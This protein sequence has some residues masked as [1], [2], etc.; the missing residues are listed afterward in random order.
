MTAASQL[1][2]QIATAFQQNAPQILQSLV[3][4]LG[5]LASTIVQNAP[6]ILAAALNLA[7]AIASGILKGIGAVLH[8]IG[9]LL[10]SLGSKILAYAPSL[11]SDGGRLIASLANGIRN[12]ASSVWAAA[13]G[14]AEKLL[15]P[16]ET[17]KDKIK[18]IIEKIKDFFAFKVSMPKIPVPHFG[19]SPS[20]WRVKD[21]LS[22]T[23]PHLSVKWYAKG[24]VF[25]GPSV[26]G[27]GEAGPEAVVP[28]TALWQN[29][30]AMADS[31]VNGVGTMLAASS[32][33]GAGTIHITLNLWPNGP[34]AGEWIV[35]T[36]DE[37]KRK[38]G[39]WN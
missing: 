32:G 21:L 7:V 26:I 30:T 2:S 4:V 38:K 33:G 36:Y 11:L 25:D 23:I 1:I 3:S 9:S 5:Q 28:L 29:F 35:N 6:Q 37:Y 20:G 12:A 27:V 16:I 22:G 18:G 10:M 31:V 17:V 19:I 8:A 14:V 34:K 13:K 15:K 24:G 39:T